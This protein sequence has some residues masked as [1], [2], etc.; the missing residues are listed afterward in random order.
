M[1]TPEEVKLI[2]NYLN[3]EQVDSKELDKLIK[4]LDLIVKQIEIQDEAN[5]KL[6]EIRVELD[7]LDK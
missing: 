4:K 1:I 6:A 3:D 5:Q 7:K 2:K